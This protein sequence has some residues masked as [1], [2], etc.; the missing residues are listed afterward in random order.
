M[1][2][3]PPC[4]LPRRTRRRQKGTSQSNGTCRNRVS[5]KQQRLAAPGHLLPAPFLARALP[6]TRTGQGCKSG[7]RSA[8]ACAL[9]AEHFDDLVDVGGGYDAWVAAGLPSTK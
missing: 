3:S 8:A 4:G 7:R 1:L 9:L 5:E 6:P 2:A